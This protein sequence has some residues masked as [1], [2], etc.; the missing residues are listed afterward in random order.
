MQKLLVVFLI[1]GVLLPLTQSSNFDLQERYWTEQE[2]EALLRRSRIMESQ[3]S[4]EIILGLI[5][6]IVKPLIAAI[7]KISHFGMRELAAGVHGVIDGYELRTNPSMA[8]LCMND[9]R[10]GE[11]ILN[12]ILTDSDT[13]SEFAI[14]NVLRLPEMANVIA[15]IGIH[16]R[17]D[18]LIARI[19]SLIVKI[20][21]SFTIIGI[22][23]VLI[24]DVPLI[25]TNS[26]ALIKDALNMT[27]AVGRLDF[28]TFGLGAGD[29][30]GIL[31][32]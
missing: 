23:F 1:L 32:R 28:Y 15:S 4:E 14:K 8:R 5:G 12:K 20:G 21:A 10:N 29:I 17:I 31:L 11:N 26:P 3:Y 18:Q 27:L 30:I 6:N 13:I 16:C 19:T 22:P 7:N 2:T 25:L 9:T 24:H